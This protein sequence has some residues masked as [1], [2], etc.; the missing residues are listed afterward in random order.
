MNLFYFTAF[1]PLVL[2]G[3][4]FVL[5]DR[6]RKAV[7]CLVGLGAIHCLLVGLTLPILYSLAGAKT[8]ANWKFVAEIWFLNNSGLG[9]NGKFGLDG[10]GVTMAMLSGVV[11]GAALLTALLESDRPRSYFALFLI[12]VGGLFGAFTSLDLFYMY[13]FHEFALVPT[14]LLMWLWGRTPDKKCQAL[15]TAI[16]LNVGALLILVGL[17]WVRFLPG[18]ASFDVTA[19]SGVNVAGADTFGAKFVPWMLMVGFGI[20]STVWPFHGW[21]PGCY[22]TAPVPA[23]MLHAGVLK[24]FGIYGLFRLASVLGLDSTSCL[25]H[26]VSWLA[27]ANIVF[28]GLIALQQKNLNLTFAYGSIAHVGIVLLGLCGGTEMSWTGAI[29]AMLASGI[30]AALAFGTVGALEARFKTSE[31]PTLTGLGRRA[32]WLAS[33]LVVVGFA[34]CGLPGFL[35]F[36]GEVLVLLGA[37]EIPQLRLQVIFMA[38][39]VLVVAA[40]YLLTV[41]RNTVHGPA[42][43]IKCVE[44]PWVERI[45]TFILAGMLLLGGVYPYGV[46]KMGSSFERPRRFTGASLVHSSGEGAQWEKLEA[47]SSGLLKSSK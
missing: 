23:V 24:A 33:M 27:V 39:G 40:V 26:M 4:I 14:F 15:Q 1:P 46:V 12:M 2:A 34:G 21:A 38:V 47:I 41:I 42:D 45:P 25:V 20:L 35:T 18:V 32:P 44:I 22:M 19:L 6:H 5:G 17:I 11:G 13:V 28:G 9:I 3:L 43:H 37:W 7:R 29:V 31:I 36:V 30:W 10:L 16:Y 8:P